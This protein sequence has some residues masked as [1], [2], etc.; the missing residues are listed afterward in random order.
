MKHR[1]WSI[2]VALGLLLAT[3]VPVSAAGDG[4]ITRDDAGTY[5]RYDGGTDATLQGCS[6]GR[7]V[8]NEPSVA[9]DPSDTDVIVAGA[10]DYCAQTVDGDVWAGYYRST[11]GASSWRNSL[12]PGYPGDDSPA[13]SASPTR[14]ACSAA[15]DPTQSFDAAGRLFYGFICFNRAKPSN[16][17]IYVATYGDHGGSYLRTVRVARGTP[18]V[19]GLF[20]DKIN[21]V[22]D[23]T[24]GPYSGNLYVAWVLYRGFSANNVVLVSRSTDHGQTF[25]RPI[26]VSQG[27]GEEQFADLAVG[28]DGSVYLTYRTFD[29]QGP[30][31]DA[32]WV[33]RS[34]NG[35]QSFERPRRVAAIDAFDSDIYGGRACG[36]GPFACPT[37]LT[38]SRFAS[39]SAVAA[40]ESGVHVVWNARDGDGQARI[41]AQNLSG[42][43]R[44]GTA[45]ATLDSVAV[46][47]QW[48]PDVASADGVIAVVFYDSRNDPAYSADRPPGNTSIGVNSGDV[49]ETRLARSSDGGATWAEIVLSA[50]RSN[51]G[52]ETGNARRLGFAGDYNYISSVTGATFAAWTDSRNLVPGSDPRETGDD[53]DED[54]FDV[55][56]PCVYDPNDIDA[57]TYASPLISDPCLSMGGLDYDIFGAAP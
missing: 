2:A 5:L 37:G 54:G 45:P 39:L 3:V 11:D 42:D 21:V 50:E 30:T 31:S 8:Q 1:I 29:V 41:Y 46:G 9:I 32:I 23:Q 10:N 47:H 56:Q 13:G 43:L 7:R 12:V 24:D 17:S 48:F 16:G 33:T 14:G 44:A 52:W 6:T 28:P 36:D 55:Y 26:S 57:A 25:S 20:H 35:G 27:L 38:F 53:S 15:G 19:A 34:T 4:I 22:A 40:D 51:F 18:S 49:V